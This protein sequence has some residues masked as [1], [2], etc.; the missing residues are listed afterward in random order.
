[1]AKIREKCSDCFVM[2]G[3]T[4]KTV[5]AVN[6]STQVGISLK[7]TVAKVALQTTVAPEFSEK[8]PGS[9]TIN[10]VKLSHAASQ[11][12]VVA[13]EPCMMVLIPS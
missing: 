3:S 2:S 1:M 8:Y 13:E 6:T 5:G 12:L 4:A 7:S 9:I 11:S 10:S